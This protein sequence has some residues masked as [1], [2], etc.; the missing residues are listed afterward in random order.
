MRT[1]IGIVVG[2]VVLSASCATELYPGPRKSDSELVYLKTDGTKIVAIDG[3]RL[4]SGTGS[5]AV[6]PGVHGV[7]VVLQDPQY[8]ALQWGLLFYSN[9]PLTLCFKGYAGNA[10]YVRPRYN[11]KLW[12]PEMMSAK[13]TELIS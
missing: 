6:L 2:V 12:K 3:I 13:T 5:F 1:P 7:S 8:G 11:A 10:Y 4:R 9:D